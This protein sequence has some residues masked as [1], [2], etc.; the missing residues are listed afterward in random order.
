MVIT[1]PVLHFIAYLREGI[2]D[3]FLCINDDFVMPHTDYDPHLSHMAL[4]L[5]LKQ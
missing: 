5:A 4:Y 2:T 3:S 1:H